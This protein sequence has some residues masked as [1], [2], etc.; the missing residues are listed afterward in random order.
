VAITIP[1]LTDFDGKGIDRAVKKFGQLETTGAKA[2]H[3]VRMAAIPAGVALVAL[4]A[5]AFD[6]AKGAVADQA[7]QEKLALT[8]DKTTKATAEQIKANEDFIT[9]TSQATAVAD[10]ELRPALAKLAI[11]T[12]DLKKAQEG[13]GLA[14]DISAATG[15]P[16][17]AVSNSLSKAYAGNMGALNKLDPT[18][19]ELV[20]SGA[21]VDDVMKKLGDRFGGDASA[22]ANTAEGRMKSL[23]IAFDE[24]KE[25]VGAALLPAIQAILPVL[26]KLG[27]WAQDHPGIFLALAAAIGVV[28]AAII[29]ANIAMTLLAMNPVV[30]AIIAIVAAI[31]ALTIG[32]VTL[33]K[34]SETF[35]DVVN[36][37]WDAVKET[38][39]TVVDFLKG[40]VMAAWDVIRGAFDVIKGIITGDFSLAWD[41]LKTTIG[42]V[43]DWI[44][45]TLLA[46]PTLLL[47]LAKDIGIAIVNG[48]VSGLATVGEATWNAI[49]GVAGY[50]GTKAIEWA[51]DLKDIGENVISWIVSGVGSLASKI[52]NKIKG[53]AGDLKESLDG[54]AEK[55]KELGSGI[56]DW[57]VNAA[58]GA[59]EGLGGILK[60]AVL[61]PIRWIAS[62][63]YNNWPDL[64]GLPGPPGFLKTLTTVGLATGGIVTGPTVAL[65]GEAGTEAVVP[66]NRANEFGF[67]GGGG[68]T[69]NV[70]A[71][72]V[73]TPDQV[74]QQIIE[75][76]QQ[77]QRRSGPV[78]AAA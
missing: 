37:A 3:G 8:L 33:Y 70:Q 72:L 40:P 76:I 18:M 15:K 48:I 13:L 64:P 44:K 2:A 68:M 12:G 54:I 78:F 21:S 62:K 71:G 43:V 49:K 4:G 25:S 59:V 45:S 50:L 16:L 26:Q 77:A 31:A 9:A 28:A 11:G 65:I 55:I 56:G 6:A 27:Q 10:D 53:L 39:G 75:A 46:L 41:G 7:A 73:A 58:K 22:A 52:W 36:G 32:L 61:A 57:I 29:G 14:L 30:L 69:I 19:K 5:A 35:R 60:S 1:I 34:K 23:G 24:T 17:E 74:G 66:L 42:G 47:T 67:G 38:I 51:G 63:I 20:K